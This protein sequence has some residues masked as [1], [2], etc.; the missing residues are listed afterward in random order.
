MTQLPCPHPNPGN[1]D[2]NTVES[3]HLRIL[4]DK[5]QYFGQ[6]VFEEKILKDFSL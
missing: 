6:L 1:H 2:F 5:C 3:G 4:P